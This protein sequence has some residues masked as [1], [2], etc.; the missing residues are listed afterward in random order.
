MEYAGR[1]HD[2][3]FAEYEKWGVWVGSRG[4]CGARRGGCRCCSSIGSV[5]AFMFDE[6]ISEPE[7]GSGGLSN[8]MYLL[9]SSIIA[10][11]TCHVDE[12]LKC[13]RVFWWILYSDSS[14]QCT[15]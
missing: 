14:P 3:L 8:A 6:Q 1:N 10:R 5:N 4:G 11:S 15:L 7:I 9:V 12:Q 13:C 2:E